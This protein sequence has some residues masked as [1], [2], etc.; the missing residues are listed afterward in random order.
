MPSKTYFTADTSQAS[1]LPH[2]L[3]VNAAFSQRWL[4]WEVSAVKYVL[5]GYS[6]SDNS[7]QSMLQVWDLRKVLISYYIKSIIYYTVRSPKL[8]EWLENPAIAEAVKSTT[9]RNFADLDPIFNSNIDEDFDFRSSGITRHSFCSVYLAWI[10]HC[11]QARDRALPCSRDSQVVTLCFSLSLL[12]RRALGAA[13]NNS[14][15]SVE[16]FLIGLHALFKGDFRITCSR[17]EWVFSD[18]ELLRKVVAP[19]VR[20]SLKL[21]QDHF[22]S[23]DE[24]EESSVLYDAICQHESSLV[25][26][27]EGDP[28]WRTAVLSG[29]PSLLALRHVVD[30]GTDEYKIIMLNKRHLS[31]RVIKLNRECVR[32]LWAGQQQE[33]I[34][35]RNRNPER[36]SIQNA[37]QALR[38][39][40]NSSCDQPIGYPI[41][42]SPLTTSYSDTNEQ[43]R[44]VV[45]G[46]LSLKNIQLSLLSTWQRVKERCVEACSSASKPSSGTL[47]SL[48]GLLGKEGGQSIEMQHLRRGR[49]VSGDSSGTPSLA[50]SRINKPPSVV[51][52]RIIDPL[53]VYDNMNLGRRI[54]PQW[55]DP[56]WRARG[57]RNA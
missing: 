11:C 36:G 3:S 21:H 45:G 52:A 20:M 33:L 28:A 30:D 26:S 10:Q 43:V 6:I 18:M 39:L 7:A 53:Q 57:G 44:S 12:G 51:I 35:L 16:F 48:A 54:D 49:T 55:P 27:H 5:E 29:A 56:E 23:P 19:A 42:V 9:E 2:M 40:I 31:F 13:S 37:K 4:A 47:V 24:Y 46:P 22:M 14:L 15:T 34:F 50:R 17:D 25:I 8:H 1:H 41:Y 32:G 38:N